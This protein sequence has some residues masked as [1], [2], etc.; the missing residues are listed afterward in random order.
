LLLLAAPATVAVWSGWVR[1]GQMTGFGLVRP[2]PGLWDSFQVNTAITLPIGVEA[3]GAYALRAWLAAGLRTSERTRRFAK[4]SGIG[5][6]LLGMSGQVAYHLLSEARVV[7]AP[8]AITTAVAC[9]PVLV[10]GMG[11]ALSHLL[12]SD[13]D[14]ENAQNNTRPAETAR[15]WPGQ[16]HDP[17]GMP[18]G[19]DQSLD[20]GQPGNAG[21]HGAGPDV[22]TTERLE[23][24][25]VTA[26][27][28]TSIGV[29]VSRR[30]LRDAGLRGSNAELSALVKAV[31]A[32]LAGCSSASGSDPYRQT[33]VPDD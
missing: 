13:A 3:Y 1:L 9:L 29:R 17:D 18:L 12:H 20:Q 31:T 23:I 14:R 27:R 7:R 25:R 24:A 22:T 33:E 19:P 4:W 15:T 16:A 8:W 26:L 2:F 5:S 6:L 11:A 30:T 32:N 28:L 10:L 21:S